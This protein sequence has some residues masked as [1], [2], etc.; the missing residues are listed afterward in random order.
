VAFLIFEPH[1]LAEV[2]RRIRRFF[3]LWPF[4]K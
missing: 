3:A 1:G 2:W 4:P